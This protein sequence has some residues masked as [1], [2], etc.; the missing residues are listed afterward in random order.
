M[1]IMH[2]SKIMPNLI[3]FLYVS[4]RQ[5]FYIFVS[6][7][8]FKKTIVNGLVLNTFMF[9]NEKNTFCYNYNDFKVQR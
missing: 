1:R 2:D 9:K 5:S 8:L 6:V 4:K 7:L 3:N